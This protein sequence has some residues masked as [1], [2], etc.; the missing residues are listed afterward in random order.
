MEFSARAAARL[1]PALAPAV[2][3][4]RTHTRA[5]FDASCTTRRRLALSAL[6]PP[7]ARQFAKKNKTINKVKNYHDPNWDP[8]RDHGE[9]QARMQMEKFTTF[10][11][12][13]T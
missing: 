2:C 8:T 10:M 1:P 11:Q 13:E 6:E 9:L 3:E 7:A 5:A 12:R 4:I